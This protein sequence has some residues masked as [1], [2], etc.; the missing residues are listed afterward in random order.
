[1]TIRIIVQC[2]ICGEQEKIGEVE[3]NIPEGLHIKIYEEDA[4]LLG[5]CEN[6]IEKEQDA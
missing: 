1:M 6:C 2:D 3:I 4:I 5:I